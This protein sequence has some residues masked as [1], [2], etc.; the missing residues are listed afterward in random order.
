MDILQLLFPPSQ[1]PE[2]LYHHDIL[3][4]LRYWEDDEAWFGMFDNVFVS[5]AY[6]GQ[7]QP[8]PSLIEYAVSLVQDKVGLKAEIE[9]QSN[10]FISENQSYTDEVRGLIMSVLQVYKKKGINRALIELTGGFDY[11]V[12]RLEF[13]GRTCDGIGFDS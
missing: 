13:T 9:R 11:R 8:D 6:E 4:D 3:G 5:I 7:S 10:Q 2:K 12:W 1:D